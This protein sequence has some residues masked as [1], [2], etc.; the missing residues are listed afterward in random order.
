LILFKITLAGLSMFVIFATT[1]VLAKA[2]SGSKDWSLLG[3]PGP[4]KV[5]RLLSIALGVG[6]FAGAAICFY[7]GTLRLLWWIPRTWGGYGDDG[8]WTWMG[9]SLAGVIAVFGAFACANVIGEMITRSVDE[10]N[11]QQQDA[12]KRRLSESNDA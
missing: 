10:R 2:A 9:D 5:D 6:A 4:R 12:F 3:A 7:S 1:Y 8:D 11:I